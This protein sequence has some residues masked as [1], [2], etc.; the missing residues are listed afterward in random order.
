[1][2]GLLVSVDAQAFC[3]TYTCKADESCHTDDD[4]CPVGGKPLYWPQRCISFSVQEDAS[5][6]RQIS[7]RAAEDALEWAYQTWTSVDCGGEPPSIDFER[8]PSVACDRIEFNECDEN[9]NVW[10]FRDREWPYNDGGGTLAQTWVQFDTNTGKIYD[11]DV[12]VNTD[13]YPITVATNRGRDQFIA[14]ATHEI[15]HVFGLDHSIRVDATMYAYYSSQSDLSE[16]TPDDIAGMC[17]VYPPDRDVNGTCDPDP[18][19]GFSPECGSEECPDPGCCAT[20]PG[21][22]SGA[23]PWAVGL[24]LALLGGLG[25]RRHRRRG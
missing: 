19:N 16:L 6:D 20:V 11:V 21:R 17:A 23:T 15:G 4:G 12:E 3:R 1:M 13:Q 24:A 5:P 25:V 8:Y 2:T 22:A 18:Y 14:V 9:A 7:L 10:V